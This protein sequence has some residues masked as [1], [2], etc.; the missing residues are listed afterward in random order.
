MNRAQQDQIIG[1][2]DS[3]T[4]M[5]IATVR[6]DGFPQAT[7]VSYVNDGLT[8]YFGTTEDTQKTKNLDRNDKVSITINRE[9]DNWDEIEGLSIGATAA[10]VTDPAEQEKVSE[11]MFSKFPQVA[12]YAPP[13][14][15]IGELVIFRIEPIVISLLDYRQG[16]GHTE[17][18]TPT[19]A[20]SAA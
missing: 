2:I 10:R 16:F 14:A 3:V 18:I 1:I 9:Y 5:T 6:E 17:V 13:E 7:T 19:S 20:E 4:D 12:Q 15:D 8:I 11:L